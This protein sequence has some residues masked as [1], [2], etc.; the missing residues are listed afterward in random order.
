VKKAKKVLVFILGLLLLTIIPAYP[1]LAG[2]ALHDEILS[3]VEENYHGVIPESVYKTSLPQEIIKELKDPYSEYMTEEDFQELMDYL[4]QRI[5]GIG[6]YWVADEEGVQ[7]VDI[8]P[9][10]PAQ[11]ADLRIG[12]R[13]VKVDGRS[14]AGR[15]L[16]EAQEMLLGPA[17]TRVVLT[18]QRD[19]QILSKVI[20]RQEVDFPSVRGQVLNNNIGFIQMF[21]FDTNTAEEMDNC[22][23]AIMKQQEVKGWIIDLRDNPG[24]FVL[25][26]LEVAGFFL[27]EIAVTTLE[28]ND[29]DTILEA[30]MQESQIC[31]PVI[32]LVDADT[33][34]AAEILAAALKDYD[35]ALLVGENTYGKGS[36]Q[37][38]FT[39]SNGDVLKLTIAQFYSPLGHS[40]DGVGIAPDIEVGSADA[41]ET[42]W[43]F[44]TR[45]GRD[46]SL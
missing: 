4:E 25:S 34:S 20:K 2:S 8:L 1:V 45:A 38:F 41:L 6:I 39:L 44:L 23:R 27:P 28:E 26:A 35:R 7:I 19:K 16:E 12:D 42:A 17:G 11:E 9:A 31:E 18:V 36:A 40:I 5:G 10:S 13:I 14:L 3:I 32:L 37:R 46:S 15:S 24:G 33:A 21:S 29:K 43:L 22:I 30:W